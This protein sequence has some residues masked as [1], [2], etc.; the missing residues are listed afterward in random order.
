MTR[1]AGAHGAELPVEERVAQ[2]LPTVYG[3]CARLGTGRIDAEDAAH[4]VMMI[5]VRRHDRLA[6]R[7]DL[8]AWL[9]GVCRRVVANHRRRAWFRR[10]LPGAIVDEPVAPDRTDAA[11]EASELSARVGRALDRLSVEHREVLVLCY[12]EDRAVAEAAALL[13]VPDGTVKSRLHHAR[14]R[15]HAA[16]DREGA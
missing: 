3:W 11:S 9:F 14:A 2:W 13:G 15:F 4:D 16:F 1:A 8:G 5:L 10:W 7:D 6:A 12:F